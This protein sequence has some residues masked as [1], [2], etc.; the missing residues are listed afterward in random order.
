MLRRTSLILCLLLPASVTAVAGSARAEDSTP[1]PRVVATVNGK[2]LTEPEFWRRCE[3]VVGGASDTAVGYHALREWL[4]QSLAE[5]EARRK[6]L[7]PT[8][9]DVE[10]R[11]HAVQRQFEFRGQNFDQWLESHGRTPESLRDDLRQQLIVENLL[12]EGVKVSDTEVALYYANN[13]GL[14]GIG[15]QIRASRITVEDKDAARDADAALK[16]GTPFE[17]V[18]RKYSADPFKSMGGKIPDP[19]DAEPRP[20]GLLEKEVLEKALRLEVGKVAGPIKLEDY[21][22]FVRLDE[23]LPARAPDLPD[24]QDLILANL[25]I[26]KGGSARLKAAQERID[27]LQREA[28]VEIFRPEYRYLL[29]AFQKPAE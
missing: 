25:K 21:W 28:K 6:G 3:R 17:E 20:N 10:R 18:A 29:K 12:T 5:E 1:K 11:A 8:S 16:K 2:E 22:V 23:K 27:Q 14:L 4:Q 7:L 24:V 26:Q 19:V 9:Q 15:E 13:K